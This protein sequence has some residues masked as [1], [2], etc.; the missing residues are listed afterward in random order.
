MANYLCPLASFL[1]VLTDAGN[2]PQVGCLIWTYA[3]GTSTPVTTFADIGGT[4][5]SNPIQLNSAGRLNNVSIWQ[6]GGVAIKVQFSTNAG[7]VGAPLFGQQIGPTF[8]QVSGINDPVAVL[9]LLANPAGGSGV[10]L[11]ANAMRSYD[12]VASVRAAPVP[13]LA[14]GETLVIEVEGGG[15]V[16]DANG[17]LFY[18]N[19]SS[20]QADDGGQTTIQPTAAIVGRYIRL[21]QSYGTPGSFTT[22]VTGCT[23]SPTITVNY[24]KN[25]T[26]ITVD[27]P[28]IG[29]LVSNST[30]FG[31]A[32]WP[33][34]LRD[35]LIGKVS[36]LLAA[37]D[38]SV[39]GVAAYLSF[40]NATGSSAAAF[41][42]NN[43]SGSWTAS[44]NKQ[45]LPFT[46]SYIC[47]NGFPT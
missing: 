8:D 23:T 11:V 26:M 47:F 40:S 32:S 37:Q 28:N 41:N 25:G 12:L 20:T 35:N 2:A 9:A 10:D 14:A 33:A 6:P 29:P 38:N 7:T 34:G 27:V 42:I 18:W 30:L 3:A 17:G 1:Q 24:I 21:N 36:P 31:L 16:N 44:N 13:V 4:P 19:A 5:N 46:F 22:T 45:I 15:V 43:A 39:S